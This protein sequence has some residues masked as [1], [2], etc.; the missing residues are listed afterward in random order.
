MLQGIYDAPVDD[1]TDADGYR[2]MP[3][4]IIDL[5]GA[6]AGGQLGSA[7]DPTVQAAHEAV[8]VA[9]I[10]HRHHDLG[11]VRADALRDSCTLDVRG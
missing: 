3:P 4:V 9:G 8:A 7:P 6:L 2:V 10:L 11:G 5:Q 1:P